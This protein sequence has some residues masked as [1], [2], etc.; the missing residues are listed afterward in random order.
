MDCGGMIYLSSIDRGTIEGL[1]LNWRSQFPDMGV[2]AMIP[3]AEKSQVAKLQAQCRHHQIPICGAIFPQLIYGSEFRARGIC[4]YRF[5]TMPYVALHT[6]VPDDAHESAQAIATGVSAELA[7]DTPATLFL[8]LDGQLPN[9]STLL[10]EL[11]LRLANRVHYAGANAGS[12]TF[13][14]MPCLFDSHSLV[15]NGVLVILLKPHQGAVLEHGYQTHAHSLPATSTDGNRIIHIDW[16]PAF[17]V[18]QELVRGQFG[19]EI[20]RENFYRYAV[21]FPFGIL[22]ANHCTLVRIPVMLDDDNALFCIGEVPAHAMLTLLAA[23]RVDSLSTVETLQHGLAQLRGRPTANAVLLFY[24]AGRRQHL[25]Q[26]AAAEEL[27]TFSRL[28]Q[29]CCVAGALALGEIGE[30]TLGGYPL[31]QNATLVTADWGTGA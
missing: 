24:C 11:Y 14:P 28:T 3:E 22:R 26:T 1:L 2:L 31:F 20:T 25:G 19:V 30:S 5:D 6:G 18:Y 13:Q 29:A 4:L 9:I 23:P 8:L 12:E 10:D 7:D 15:G 16:R 17:E 27:H 21:H